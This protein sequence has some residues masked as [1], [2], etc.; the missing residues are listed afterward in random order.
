M[1]LLA[2]FRRF[3]ACRCAFVFVHVRFCFSRCGSC[4]RPFYFAY[5]CVTRGTD[6]QLRKVSLR[7]MIIK[8]V[9]CQ[10]LPREVLGTRQG[11]FCRCRWRRRVRSLV[12]DH[13]DNVRH[14]VWAT[15]L[16][17]YLWFRFVASSPF[18]WCRRMLSV[19]ELFALRVRYLVKCSTRQA[20]SSVCQ[21]A[22]K[23]LPRYRTVS[24]SLFAQ[25]RWSLLHVEPV[26]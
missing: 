8:R 11:T 7:E 12:Q 24:Q 14:D 6:S 3:L 26:R 15:Y 16:A 2:R 23:L 9:L 13:S 1:S 18:L 21:N 20:V 19:Y 25:K 5:V 10:C 17:S 4:C 22:V